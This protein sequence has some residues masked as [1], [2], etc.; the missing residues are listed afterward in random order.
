MFLL[1]VCGGLQAAIAERNPNP[2]NQSKIYDDYKL[3][4]ALAPAPSC[5]RKLRDLWNLSFYW[6]RVGRKSVCFARR[7]PFRLIPIFSRDG[8]PGFHVEWLGLMLNIH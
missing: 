5:A 8:W 4:R 2:M 6:F 3:A 7:R 1:G